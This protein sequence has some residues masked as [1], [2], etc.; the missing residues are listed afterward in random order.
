ML[1]QR[2]SKI[3]RTGLILF[4]VLILIY[5]IYEA[6]GLL[7]GPK[8]N[9]STEITVVHDPYVKVQGRAQRIVALSMNGKQ[10]P[11]TEEGAFS[12]PFLLAKG[13][14]RI[15]LEAKDAYG[16]ITARYVEIM[17]EPFE[18]ASNT[19]ISADSNTT[20]SNLAP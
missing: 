11:V 15:A 5:G 3:V 12:E 20:T 17:Y 13:G 2:D 10:I 7:F 6:Q 19:S 1:P 16:R 4:F 8:I 14:N 18:E 9:V